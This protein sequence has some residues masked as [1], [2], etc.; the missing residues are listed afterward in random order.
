VPCPDVF[1]QDVP[2]FVVKKGLAF[3]DYL[4]ARRPAVLDAAHCAR[5]NWEAFFFADLWER[6]RFLSDPLLY[7]GLLTDP[8]SRQRFRPSQGAPR[9]QHAGVTYYFESEANRAL[10][11]SD[12]ETFRLPGWKM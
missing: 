1:V 4:D 8:I 12:P 7:C 3:A 10:F 2:A 6:E 5:L 9:F 11:E